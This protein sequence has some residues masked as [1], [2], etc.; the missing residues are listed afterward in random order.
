MKQLDL[1]VNHSTYQYTY[2]FGSSKPHLIYGWSDYGKQYYTVVP[3]FLINLDRNETYG[4]S[5][6]IYAAYTESTNSV[7]ITLAHGYSFHLIYN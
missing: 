3:C 5:T 6:I 1:E 2:N 4:D 7:S